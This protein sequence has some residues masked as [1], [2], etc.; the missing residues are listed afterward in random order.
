MPRTRGVILAVFFIVMALSSGCGQKEREAK[1]TPAEVSQSSLEENF[2][3]DNS[4]QK[5]LT[6]SLAGYSAEG[7]KN[8]DLKGDSADVLT[9]NVVLLDNVLGHSYSKD[10]TITITADKGE[11]DK[12]Q[13]NL[14]LKDNVVARTADGAELKTNCL[15]WNADNEEVRTDSEVEISRENMK[16]VGR[17]AS[18]KPDLEKMQLEKN[19]S[20]T[21]APTTVIT[22]DGPL[23]VDGQNDAAVFKNNVLVIDERGKIWADMVKVFFEPER[24]V[25]TKV[26]AQG[27]VKI[28]R[29]QNITL[30]E[31]AAYDAQTK[32]IILTGKPKLM[33]YSKEGLDALTGN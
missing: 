16:A 23:E 33:F 20:L 11:F 13:N 8:W 12:N 28:Q 22:C 3:E 14:E 6:F 25:I 30:S 7:E 9:N 19:V 2:L 21:I 31:E 10:S 32:V 18:G 24:K 17:G 1:K 15:N 4:E 29:G 5:I 26:F 27:N